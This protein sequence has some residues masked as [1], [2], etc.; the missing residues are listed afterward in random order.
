MASCVEV[1]G[2]A[3]LAPASPRGRKGPGLFTPRPLQSARDLPLAP[4]YRLLRR[5]AHLGVRAGTAVED[6]VVAHP[7]SGVEDVIVASPEVAIRCC[8]SDQQVASLAATQLVFAQPTVEDVGSLSSLEG[9]VAAASLN[10]VGTSAPADNVVSRGAGEDVSARG[11]AQ[12]TDGLSGTS[13]V[14][15]GGEPAPRKTP[16]EHT[17]GNSHHALTLLHRG[18]RSGFARRRKGGWRWHRVDI[19]S[20]WVLF[21]TGAGA[22][23]DDLRAIRGPRRAHIVARIVGEVGVSATIAV[24]RP[25]LPW[26]ATPAHLA[27]LHEHDL[28]PVWGPIWCL[29]VSVEPVPGQDLFVL[30][31][32]VHRDDLPPAVPDPGK[33][34]LRTVGGPVGAALALVGLGEVDGIVGG[35]I[36]VYHED[37]WLLEDD[38]ALYLPHEGELSTRWRPRRLVIAAVGSVGEV[39]LV[40]AVGVHDVDVPE[41]DAV[42]VKVA[43]PRERDL[44]TVGRPGRLTF[45]G[46]GCVGE[47]G[48]VGAVGVHHP[49]VI[50]GVLLIAVFTGFGTLLDV[51]DLALR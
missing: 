24:D 1:E 21:G 51:D 20:R 2:D 11:A 31:V 37:V 16:D 50:A 29:I 15:L 35:R 17:L 5:V 32:R 6:I 45:V 46:I 43:R 7:V 34:N 48:L 47:V 40:C 26:L 22:G 25:D 12:G 19:R 38:A 33:S 9:I 27:L 14:G 23:E 39:G 36:R 8:S 28:R 10:H 49:D 4:Y 44:G 30:A 42:F 3:P 41:S 13:P 18:R